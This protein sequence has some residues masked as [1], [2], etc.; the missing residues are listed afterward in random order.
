[1]LQAAL[2]MKWHQITVWQTAE[3]CSSA[4]LLSLTAR[5][6]SFSI[7]FSTNH[8]GTKCILQS[9]MPKWIERVHCTMQNM[10]FFLNPVSQINHKHL[11][12]RIESGSR[13]INKAVLVSF[14][15]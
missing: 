6:P 5:Q 7:P 11:T 8:P 12:V 10:A 1:L 15:K 14:H 2:R 4:A 3:L 9:E 13:V